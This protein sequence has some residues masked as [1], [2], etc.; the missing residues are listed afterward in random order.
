[1]NTTNLTEAQ[2]R[3]R[4]FNAAV[5][6]ECI[7]SVKRAAAGAM[8]K[9]DKKGADLEAASKTV[10]ALVFILESKYDAYF[11]G[12]E[13]VG[14]KGV[15]LLIRKHIAEAKEIAAAAPSV[16]VS[17]QEQPVAVE[18]CDASA[19]NAAAVT[20]APEKLQAAAK[21]VCATESAYR[22]AYRAARKAR[23]HQAVWSS[24]FCTSPY[25]VRSAAARVYLSKS[26]S[27]LVQFDRLLI[28]DRLEQRRQL[29][30]FFV[31]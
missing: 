7:A 28:A 5:K 3:S 19:S 13:Y 25:S 10:A 8:I 1:M 6:A 4:A 11:L 24:N 14:E 17:E 21:V 2:K 31:A 18:A 9:L 12:D 29:N 23:D 27:E 30:A 15:M 20:V 26:Q 22:A 16:A